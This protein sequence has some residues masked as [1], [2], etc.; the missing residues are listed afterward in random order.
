MIR[1]L[2]AASLLLMLGA[3]SPLPAPPAAGKPSPAG[4]PPPPMPDDR[5][6]CPA[7]VKLCPDGSYVSRDPTRG[8]AFNPCPGERPQ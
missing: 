5:I 2:A 6:V 8:C 1:L 4:P 3:C 7:D